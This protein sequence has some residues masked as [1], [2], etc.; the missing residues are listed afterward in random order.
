MDV[1]CL[2]DFDN[3]PNQL[4][5]GGLATLSA[6]FDAV[7]ATQLQA[8]DDVFLRLYGGW[9]SA[10]G[11]S[12][13]GTRLTQEIARSFPIVVAQNGKIIRHKHCEIASSLID[14]KGQL[15]GWTH[16]Q[17]HG[18]RS[19]VSRKFP[20]ACLSQSGCLIDAVTQWSRG[21]CPIAGCNVKKED[22][23]SY[24]EQKLVDTLLCCDLL[25]LAR[26]KPAPNI[27]VFS[28]DDDLLPAIIMAANDCNSIWRCRMR[29]NPNSYYDPI[30]LQAGIQSI[31]L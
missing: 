26:R 3:I 6:R 11:L 2:A 20:A 5:N 14:N 24:A 8:S 31:T 18:I 12:N 9:Y 21:S 17:R 15:L 28:D 23:F 30:L 1:F 25:A 16:R 4:K 10:S 7:I 13:S 22:A 19:R 27:F 29:P